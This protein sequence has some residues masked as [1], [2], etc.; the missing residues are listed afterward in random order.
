M[1]RIP[2]AVL[3]G[4]IARYAGAGRFARGFAR[5]KLK[6]DP[7]YAAVVLDRVLPEDGLLVDLGCGRGLLL[8]ALAA[9]GSRLRLTGVERRPRAAAVARAALGARAAIVTA[10]LAS[11]AVPPCDAVAL[12]DVLHYLD[13]ATQ[14]DLL[15][16]AARALRPGGV[17]VAREADAGAGA[18]FLA[19]RAAERLAAIAR[20]DLGQRFHYRRRAEWVAAVAALGL[21]VRAQPMADGTPF[22]NDLVVGRVTPP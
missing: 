12:L 9:A 10:D 16:R 3:T 21:A 6:R 13:R 19:L 17:L 8:A 15:A 14:D 22:A 11:Y 2:A 20:G 4:A 5:G 1:T 7:V 18:R